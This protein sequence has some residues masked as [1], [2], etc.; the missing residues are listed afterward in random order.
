MSHMSNFPH[1]QSILVE[2]I[3]G[4]TGCWI[5]YNKQYHAWKKIK[6]FAYRPDQNLLESDN[7]SVAP[8]YAEYPVLGCDPEE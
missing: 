2:K 7:F 8:D 1:L 4:N 3:Y 6:Y 5:N